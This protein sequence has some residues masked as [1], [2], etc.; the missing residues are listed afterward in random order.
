MITPS[1]DMATV[2]MMVWDDG[3]GDDTWKFGS[4]NVSLRAIPLG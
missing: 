4:G 1:V 3:G 2:G